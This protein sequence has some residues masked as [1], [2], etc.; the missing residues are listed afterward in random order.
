MILNRFIRMIWMGRPQNKVKIKWSPDFAYAIG[1]LTTDG[2]LSSDGR[3]FDLT[4]QDKEQLLN[5]RACLEIKNKI[6]QKISGQTQRKVFRI[7]FGDVNFYRFLLRVG[8]TENKSKTLGKLEIPNQYFFD[9]LRGHLDGDGTFHS[10]W[11]PRWKSSFMLYTIFISASKE[12][13]NWLQKKILELAKIRGHLTKARN[14]SCY[15]LRYAKRE[16]LTLLPKIYSK[17][18][19]VRL[20]RK[21]LK[22]KRALAIIGEGNLI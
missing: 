1:L 8:L 15:N 5:F 4:S 2:N 21:Y 18:G 7:Q 17:N 10:Y 13:I 14:N 6:G 3:H 22:I 12:H 20:S 11:D 19:C 9:F 16:S